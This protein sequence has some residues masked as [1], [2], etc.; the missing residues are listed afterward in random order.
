MVP[1]RAPDHASPLRRSGP[2]FAV[3][4]RVPMSAADLFRP[5]LGNRCLTD[6]DSLKRYGVDWTKV[7]APAPSAVLLPESIEEVQAIV[8]LANEQRIALVPSGGRT[9]LSA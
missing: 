8:R 6:E 9:G 3:A 7:W 5:L 4:R 2:D 1:Y